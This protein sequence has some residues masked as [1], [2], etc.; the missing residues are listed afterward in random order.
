LTGLN[1]PQ[2]RVKIRGVEAILSFL[3][4]LAA[5]AKRDNNDIRAGMDDGKFVKLH[6]YV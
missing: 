2:K 6:H 3:T 1:F 5:D 4:Y